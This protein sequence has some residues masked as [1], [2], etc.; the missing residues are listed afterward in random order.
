MGPRWRA[1]FVL[2]LL[3]AFAGAI[4]GCGGSDPAEGLISNI[5]KA[6]TARTLT[7]LQQGLITAQVAS[8]DSA[9]GSA[10]ALAAALQQRDP[11][12]RYTTAPPTDVGIVQ[13]VGGGGGPVML[14]GI[15]APPSS[16]RPPYYLAAWESGGT[17]VYYIGRQPPA[18]SVSPPA[19]AGWST[20]PPVPS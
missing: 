6:R 2:G 4:A 14:V 1:I 18:Y 9:G 20:S 15:S 13:V 7:S 5:D 17:T 12:N 16:P 8:A 3:L 11:S 10:P 19:G